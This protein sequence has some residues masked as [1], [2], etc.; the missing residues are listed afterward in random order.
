[1][2][3]FV[4]EFAVDFE[5]ATL[6]LAQLSYDL[7]LDHPAILFSWPSQASATAYLVDQ[8]N[9]SYAVPHFV[10]FLRDIAAIPNIGRV[11]IVAHGLGSKLAVNALISMEPG[12]AP[13]LLADNLILV[14]P[15]MDRDVLMMNASRLRLLVDRVTI[16]VSS[17]DTVLQ[18]ATKVAGSPRAG[19]ASDGVPVFPFADTIDATAKDSSVL[20]HG[21]DSV[22]PDIYSILKHRLPPGERTG[23]QQGSGGGATYWIYK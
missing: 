9:A 15:D 8:E 4:P 11:Q 12:G 23:L 1:V 22:L 13:G 3:I 20:G 10:S 19:D 14:R 18:M 2:L 6:R 21:L 5:S 16:Y 17:K 7:A